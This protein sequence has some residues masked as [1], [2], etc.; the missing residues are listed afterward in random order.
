MWMDGWMD[1]FELALANLHYHMELG[2]LQVAKVFKGHLLHTYIYHNIMLVSSDSTIETMEWI[3]IENIQ[4]YPNKHKDSHK[5][6]NTLIKYK[7]SNAAF[8]VSLLL[9]LLL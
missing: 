4:L 6:T 3:H 7:L 2:T 9:L 8:L 1:H 5:Y